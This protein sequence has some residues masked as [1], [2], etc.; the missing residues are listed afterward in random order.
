MP[1]K[2]RHSLFSMEWW[3]VYWPRA[4]PLLYVAW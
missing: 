2:N 3:T 4:I 1:I